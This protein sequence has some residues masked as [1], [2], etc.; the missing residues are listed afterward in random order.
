MGLIDIH[1]HILPDLDNHKSIDEVIKLCMIYKQNGYSDVFGTCHYNEKFFDIRPQ[2][3]KNK[4]D[5]VNDILSK[6]K[7]DLKIHPASEIYFTK[8]TYSSLKKNRASRL[9]NSH[10]ALIE[11]DVL[12]MD[13]FYEKHLLKI[14]KMGIRPIIAHVER[15]FY[16][17]EDPQIIKKLREMGCLIQ[18]NFYNVDFNEY[19]ENETAMCLLKKHLV[20]FVA[21]DCHSLDDRSPNISNNL[22]ILRQI[23]DKEYADKILIENPKKVLEDQCIDS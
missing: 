10:Y 2:I 9:S 18:I 13:K 12:K 6:E 11:F 14:I 20:D 23:V 22:M 5:E 7:I 3:I 21:T 1:S 16:V 4:C 19:K 15:Y 17:Q 8:K